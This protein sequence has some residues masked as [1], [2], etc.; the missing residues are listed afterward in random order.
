MSSPS[1][2]ISASVLLRLVDLA[3][4]AMLILDRDQR[5]LFMNSAAVQLFGYDP[6]QA[7]GRPLELLIPGR[8][9]EPHR[10]HVQ[11]FVDGRTSERR[12]G[13]RMPVQGCRKDGSE[14]AADVTI[15]KHVADG[16][17]YLT[18]VVRDRSTQEAMEDT[19][20]T[21]ETVHQSVVRAMS[22]GIVL[23]GADGK[24]LTSNLSA[25]KIL[26][27]TADQMA[28]RTSYD[29]RWRAV[30]ED[31][32]PFLGED[33]PAMVTL[34]T[35]EPQRGVIMG[36]HH[37][38][39]KLAWISIN[40]QHLVRPDEPL[41]Y[42]VV[43]SFTDITENRRMLRELHE[44]EARYR[45]IYDN[46]MDAILLT[47]PSGEILAANPAAC[48]IFGRTEEEICR[49]GREG[50]VDLADP[51]L[52]Q[53]LEERR[54]SGR[55]R[56]ELTFIR[57]DGTRFPGE[58]TSTVFRDQDG[59]ERTSMI[60]RDIPARV[61]SQE[62]LREREEILE[63]RVAERTRELAALL[64]LSHDLASTLNLP[65]L[66]A[67]ILDHL[68][69]F[70][71]FDHTAV[72]LL[73]GGD[74]IL[75]GE[76]PSAARL[77]GASVRLPSADLIGE[78]PFEE[79]VVLESP[80]QRAPL[81]RALVSGAG[82]AEAEAVRRTASGVAI[83][84]TVKDKL[85]G[86]LTLL[87]H[88]AEAYKTSQTDL[89]QAIGHQ[90]AVAIE[91]SRLV[92]EIG[93]AATQAERS[94]L[95]RDLHDSVTQMLYSLTL[96][97]EAAKQQTD[98]GDP[99]RVGQHLA[100]IGETAQQALREMRLMVYELRPPVL[101]QVGLLEALGQRLEAV[102]RRAGVD[103]SLYFDSPARLPWPV[104]E[105]LFRIAIEALNNVLKHAAC[106]KVAVALREVSD[107]IELEVRDNGR[108]MSETQDR[109]AGGW[110]LTG[111]RE[112]AERLGGT[113]TVVSNAGMGTSIVARVPTQG[114]A[115]RR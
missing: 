73:L 110:G 103:A 95:A 17:V 111:M 109:R 81:V 88:Q 16:T 10:K 20:R 101:E 79:V 24:I 43:T 63:G 54:R 21:T 112:R 78:P 53:A 18:A 55:F 38:D 94:R 99:V 56:T 28:G 93:H 97:A 87:H 70:V 9:H 33:H 85:V 42:A 98:Q 76:Q 67:L 41:P 75:E 92:A 74:L 104:E 19:V 5:I 114:N 84:L 46:S 23:Q 69:R 35:G 61:R 39:G 6:Q 1:D 91:N 48:L 13:E 50:V 52:K 2:V 68:G 4:D 25:E 44:S 58:V 59:R 30:H 34:R 105:D 100:Q 7:A 29:P 51:R 49:L 108:G 27:L 65:S 12:M 62:A 102:E 37:P 15:A 57:G 96:F 82:E 32:S 3:E 72:W 66:M 83:P 36:V 115:G 107:G 77:S 90:A 14:F 106:T 11:A 8:F 113:L 22:E 86:C 64:Q 26:G 80:D 47:A 71:T 45:S 89:L 40:S 31:G 60:I